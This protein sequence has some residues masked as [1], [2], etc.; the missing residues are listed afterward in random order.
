MRI[1]D[2]KAIRKVGKDLTHKIFKFALCNKDEMI[3]AAKLLGFWNGRSLVFDSDEEFDIVTDFLIFEKLKQNVP[4]INRFYDS[5]PELTDFEQESM[6]GI[7]NYHSSLFEL[8]NVDST[9]NTLVLLDLL[10]LNHK[11]YT[12]MDHG[13]SQTSPVGLILYSRLLPFQDINMTSGVSFG[14]EKIYKDNL[15]SAISM[16]TFKKRN[17]LTSTE[18]FLLMHKKNQQFGLKIKTM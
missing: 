2:Y 4:V 3:Y 7:L 6:K 9:N 12:L 17:K 5:N 10:D 16:A 13:M 1:E 11:E 18:L 15:L 14:F 8:T